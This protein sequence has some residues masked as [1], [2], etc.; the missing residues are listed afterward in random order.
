M[1]AYWGLRIAFGVSLIMHGGVR[2][3]KLSGF[4]GGMSG[5]FD[6]TFL[7]GFPSLSF[8]YAIPFIEV[9]VGIAILVGGK[10]IR[11]GSFAGCLLMGG[12]MFGTC[13]LEKWEILPSQL[14]HLALFYAILM[15]PHTPDADLAKP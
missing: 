6:G 1:L 7:A 4:A 5:Q 9:A 12:I 11:W 3:P 10:V 2:F 14:I 15:N 13:V 8:A